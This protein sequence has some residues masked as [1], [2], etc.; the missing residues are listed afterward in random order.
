MKRYLQRLWNYLNPP[1]IRTAKQRV[2]KHAQNTYTSYRNLSARLVRSDSEKMVFR[3]DYRGPVKT[4]PTSFLVY[5][6]SLEQGTI[7]ELSR[8]EARRYVHFGK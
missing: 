2:I 8:E 5:E 7:R 1:E 3:V 6:Y 4:R